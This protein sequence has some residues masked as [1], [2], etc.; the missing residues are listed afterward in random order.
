MKKTCVA[1][2]AVAL[3]VAAETARAEV[4]DQSSD[5]GNRQGALGVGFY[6]PMGQ[7]F[8]AD[9]TTI[10]AAELLLEGFNGDPPTGNVTVNLRD[11]DTLG[12][13]I[14]ATAT[15]TDVVIPFEESQWI[16]F[17]FVP[18]VSVTVFNTY[19]LEVAG[20]NQA[21]GLVHGDCYY[22]LG[23]ALYT[24]DP[25]SSVT[26]FQFRTFG[27][28]G[29]GTLEPGEDC[30]DG[31]LSYDA[32][33]ER[34]TCQFVESGGSC[35]TDSNRCT[36]EECSGAAAACTVSL[37]NSSEGS[38]CDDRSICTTYDACDDAGH[39]V[40][41]GTPAT[42]CESAQTASLGLTQ[43]A[44][45]GKDKVKFKWKSGL[46]DPALLTPL[47]QTL[48]DAALCVY[49]SGDPGVVL[50]SQ[51][52]SGTAYEVKVVPDKSGT[53]FYKSK[54]GSIAGVTKTSFKSDF[55]DPAKSQVSW[56]AGGANFDD[57]LMSA[58]LTGPVT[59]QVITSGGGCWGVEFSAD[60]IKKNDGAK[61]KAVAK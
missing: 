23:E 17:D 54:D 36:L 1:L 10:T 43:S 18:D 28:C 50:S 56:Q 41:Q 51:L 57:L 59:A 13:T 29:N 14:L 2:L 11:G 27:P 39:C 3:T 20:S 42:T 25:G 47:V 26:D 9:Q 38:E 4:P 30:D 32:C 61:F 8:R 5:C 48:D 60:S 53:V 7:T 15:V 34:S 24:G 19:T 16:R 31:V 44:T 58:A 33:C 35:D 46:V 12:G 21:F 40:G 45:P 52:P 6:S 55:A 22:Y 37:G 49:S